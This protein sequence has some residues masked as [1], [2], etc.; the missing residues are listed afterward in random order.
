MGSVGA[1]VFLS[2]DES[3]A[4][5]A[6]ARVSVSRRGFRSHG[7]VVPRV[8]RLLPPSHRL[9]D[10]LSSSES[11]ALGPTTLPGGIWEITDG[12]I[13][14]VA[15]KLVGWRVVVFVSGVVVQAV[16]D[17]SEKPRSEG[18]NNP[19]AMGSVKSRG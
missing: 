19:R 12:R 5:V 18:I 15:K 14:D 16:K 2:S 11:T 3:L 1:A 7:F 8:L 6:Q 17:E 9:Y 10:G 13:L 4:R